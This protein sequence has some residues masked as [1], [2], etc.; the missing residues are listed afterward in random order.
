MGEVGAHGTF[1]GASITVVGWHGYE[2]FG[3]HDTFYE[4]GRGR[5]L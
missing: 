2:K 1:R 5:G 3:A 4:Y